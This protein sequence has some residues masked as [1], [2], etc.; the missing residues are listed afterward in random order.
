MI[1]PKRKSLKYGYGAVNAHIASE[2]IKTQSIYLL[3]RLKQR[4][5]KGN[6]KNNNE[7]KK[8]Q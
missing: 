5:K 2:T 8:K 3:Y 4:N 1:L 7:K 6:K